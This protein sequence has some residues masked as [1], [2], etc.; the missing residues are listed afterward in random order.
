MKILYYLLTAFF[1]LIGV[2]GVLRTA[3]ILATGGVFMPVQLGIGLLA[4]LISFACL[5][6]A[7]AAA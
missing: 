3:E 4:L 6:K 5:R 2:L 7:R 1:G